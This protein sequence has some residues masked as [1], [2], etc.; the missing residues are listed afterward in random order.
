MG[1]IMNQWSYGVLMNICIT[2]SC[3]DT[4]ETI[5]VKGHPQQIGSVLYQ[6]PQWVKENEEY[7]CKTPA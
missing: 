7:W 1:I 2:D 5:G 6:A 4:L 3:Y